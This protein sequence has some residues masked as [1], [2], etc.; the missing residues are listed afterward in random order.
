MVMRVGGLA[1]GM[2]IDSIVKQMMAS[3]KEP[4][5]KLTQKK[6]ILEW[7]RNDYRTMNSKLYDFSTNKLYNFKLNSTF[8][9]KQSAVTNGENISV[10]T[11]GDSAKGDISFKVDQIA[12]AASALGDADTAKL[13]AKGLQTKV[14]DYL[15]LSESDLSDGKLVIRMGKDSDIGVKISVDLENDT[16]QTFIDRINSNPGSMVTAYLAKSDSGQY[17]LSLISRTTGADS[18]VDMKYLKGGGLV[19][20]F[21]GLTETPGKNA[22]ATI[23]GIAV[24]QASNT[25][26]VNGTKITA[27]A[28]GT[29]NSTIK[30]TTNT[31]KIMDSIKAFI[32]D[33]NTMLS[34]L[35]EKVNERYYRDF[36]PLTSEQ[37]ESM[38]EKEIEQWETKAKSGQLK[39]D[40]I[41]SRVYYDMRAIIASQVDT[42]SDIYKTL[43]SIG[44]ETGKYEENGKLYLNN[45]EKLR[46]ALDDDPE[47]V[48]AL[49]RAQGDGTTDQKTIGI[50]ERLY[51]S[52]QSAMGDISDKAG[53]SKFSGSETYKFSEDSIMGK[54]LTSL[55]RQITDWTK[56]VKEIETRYYSQFTAMEKAISKYN[57]QSAAMTNM[58][59]SK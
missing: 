36:K 11:T 12:T 32:S 19:D 48:K 5:N 53:T 44:I 30:I 40:S 43:S 3:R 9:E 37:K 59:N 31:S 18:S 35:Y 34:T 14:K 17:Q 8:S 46:K 24:E 27:K 56:R 16:M 6:Q 4:L 1:S 42:G 10:E 50:A 52:T 13:T 28:E 23:N 2:D 45:E 58:F 15:N 38:K 22:K 54:N 21:S 47:A 26:T 49:F 39:N 29:G 20:V 57:N 51:R 55:N 33:Y 7:Q 41:L 25:Y